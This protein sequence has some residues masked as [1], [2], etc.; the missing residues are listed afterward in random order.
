MWLT[1][2]K[3]SKAL[4]MKSTSRHLSIITRLFYR[5]LVANTM[6]LSAFCHSSGLAHKYDFQPLQA[7]NY[8][9]SV[10]QAT[11]FD[12]RVPTEIIP[13]QP[14]TLRQPLPKIQVVAAKNNPDLHPQVATIAFNNTFNQMA[15]NVQIVAARNFAHK[16]PLAATLSYS[17]DKPKSSI[18]DKITVVAVEDYFNRKVEILSSGLTR[19][20]VDTYLVGGVAKEEGFN[21]ESKHKLYR[22]EL[23][24]AQ[25]P[26][27]GCAP[28]SLNCSRT[29]TDREDL[30]AGTAVQNNDGNKDRNKRQLL[31]P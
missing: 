11:N 7:E 19:D 23:K 2:N 25:N 30:T 5:G 1:L 27:I 9:T 29:A 31:T 15:P 22:V 4:N 20:Y 14:Q 8:V 28:L 13:V 21:R 10:I 16:Q 3:E 18:P 12:S 6:L 26:L 17:Y 24:I